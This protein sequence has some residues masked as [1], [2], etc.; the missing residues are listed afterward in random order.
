MGFFDHLNK[1]GSKAIKPQTIRVKKET[2]QSS[3]SSSK[4][5]FRPSNVQDSQNRLQLKKVVADRPAT[6]HK[7]TESDIAKV[8]AAR[9]R[10]QPSQGP[11]LSSSDDSDSEQDAASAKAR[12]KSKVESSRDQIDPDRQLRDIS[13]HKEN[14][15]A[16]LVH[17]A[18]IASAKMERKYK[19]YFDDVA[20]PAFLQY[21]GADQRERWD[22]EFFEV[23][24]YVYSIYRFELVR[25]VESEDFN[26]L[27]D[28]MQTIE[29]V[30]IH[31]LSTEQATMILDE[32]TGILRKMKRA[33]TRGQGQLF[34]DQLTVFNDYIQ[35]FRENGDISK[36]LD[37]IHRPSLALIER[38]LNQTYA[39]TVSLKVESLRKYE[40]GTDNVYGELL[41][42]F[43]SK[44]LN[45]SQI[46]SSQVFV[47]LG[48]GVANVVLQA[49]LEV[50][51]ESWGCEM[52]HNACE[53]ADLQV[54]EF[55]ARCQL[56][57]LAPGSVHLERGDF[58]TN[59]AIGKA[60]RR[61][62]VVLVNNQAFTPQLNNG[63]V[64]LFLDLKEGCQIISLK[65]FVPHDHKI[66]TRNLNSPVNLLDVSMRN[67]YSNCVSWTNAP[68][69]Y[70]I[71]KKDS[72]R[73]Q[74]FMKRAA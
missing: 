36:H 59:P 9:K 3:P 60:L 1:Q 73:L 54:T 2:V 20:V 72:R 53:L 39:R 68:G 34:L 17:G 6:Q 28:I 33:I 35:S 70:F 24:R 58:L 62:D 16:S 31:Y 30:G 14:V 55:K 18:S 61:A 25:P 15:T 40:N 32:T 74:E 13:V 47:D 71:A 45:E 23:M 44:I 21:P 5:G 42:R 8:R 43:V 49:A 52:M 66:S 4:N 11:L 22:I 50:G 10:A 27:E 19:S 67:Y 46:K 69:T 41:P 65:S 63:L 38:I 7:S 64:G 51:C 57:D 37:L 26:P 29:H 12:K 48:S 56:W